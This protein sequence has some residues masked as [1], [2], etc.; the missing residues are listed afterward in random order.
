MDYKQKYEDALNK[1]KS[2]IWN[3]KGHVLYEDDIIDLFPELAESEDER[4]RKEIIS[5]INALQSSKHTELKNYTEY[6]DWLEKQKTTE[7]TLQYLKENHSPSEVSDFQAAMNIAVAKAY[8]KGYADGLEKQGNKKPIEEYDVPNT[9][10]KV[11]EAVTSRMKY[12]DDNLKPIAKF[13]MDYANWDLRKDEWNCP[14]ATVPLFRVLDAL[15]QNGNQYSEEH[16]VVE[17]NT[18]PKFNV[19]DWVIVEDKTLFQIEKVTEL[20]D[21]HYQYW[22][23]DGHWFGDGTES[24]LWTIEDAKDGDVLYFDNLL[25]HGSGTLIY[26]T[27]KSNHYII[28]KY[29]SVNEF[30]FEPNSYVVLNDG[31]II[32]A[33]K[34][35]R[36]KLEKAIT[37]AGYKWNKEDL[38]LEKL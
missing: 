13:V 24:H 31:Y 35:Q 12:V 5:L 19:G 1:A 23:T 28:T 10:I 20:P 22:T 34:E 38:K 25:V 4:I 16:H 26:K 6:I 29:C 3:D 21:N 37:E 27:D 8:N 2:K 36:D 33:T 18:K 14:L 17:N 15:V 30:G 7:E 9:P 11:S 32:P